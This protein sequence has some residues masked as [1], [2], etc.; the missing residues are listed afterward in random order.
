MFIEQFGWARGLMGSGARVNRRRGDF[1]SPVEVLEP[2]LLF[3][4][5]SVVTFNEIMYNPAASDSGGE[6][7]ELHNQ[8]SV[9]VDLS[10]WRLSDG[11][12]YTFAEGTTLGGGDYLVVAKDP[13]ALELAAGINNVFG[14]WS[15]SLSNSGETI[16]LRDH[17]NR[18]MDELDYN[19]AG[20]FPVA[21]D[22]SGASLAKT[23][24]HAA[25]G[26]PASW[27]FS[28]DSGGTPGSVN[29]VAS[30]ALRLSEVAGAQDGAFIVEIENTGGSSLNLAGYA[31]VLA[32][33]SDVTYAL[34]GSLGAGA[35]G[36]YS[37][38]ATG[39][40][41]QD[42]D[43]L[44]LLGPGGAVIDGTRVENSAR[45]R[46][47][48]WGGRWQRPDVATFGG[49]NSFDFEEAIVINEI[50]YH[51]LPIDPVAP[52]VT[53]QQL[54][55][56]SSVWRYNQSGADQGPGWATSAHSSGVGGWQ[57]GAGVLGLEGATLAA[58][59]NTT[60]TLGPRTFYFETDF[61]FTGDPSSVTQLQLT[62]LVDDGA[63]FYLNGV[64]VGTRINLPGGT[65]NA[66]T[67]ANP[68]VDNAGLGLMT[69]DA[70]Q[71]VAGTNR[72][73]VEVHQASTTSSDI[74]MGVELE[75]VTVTDPGVPFSED[76]EEWIELY[77][78]GGV[79]V[80]LSGWQ[81]D[82]GIDFEFLPGTVLGA[83][84][85]LVIARNATALGLKYPSIT[86]AGQYDGQL[87]NS[88]ERI[89]LVDNTGNLADEV[90]YYDGGAWD[91]RAD[92]GG[93]SLELRDADADN[94]NGQAWAASEAADDSQWQTVSY[95]A[96]ATTPG[97]G[98]NIWNEFVFG[99]LDD[100][101]IL[102][103]DISVIRDPGG[104][105]Q[106]LIQ[107]GSFNNLSTWRAGGNHRDVEI[108]N[109]NGN[110]VLHLT[111]TGSAEHILNHVE[112]TLV[113]NTAIVSGETYQISYRAKW[114]SGSNQLNT[115]LYF[116]YLPHTERLAR[117]TTTGTPG[118]VNSAAE[119]NIGPTYANLSQSV[120]TPGSF[121]SVT[122]SVDAQ[123]PDGVA[124][125]RLWYR[126]NEGSWQS[127][128]MAHNGGGHYTGTIPGYSSGSIIQFYVEGTDG[129]GAQ[130]TFPADGRDS[131]ALYKVNTSASNSINSLQII[132]L[133]SESSFLHVNTNT[134]SNDRVGAT[135][136]DE[137]G[138]IYYD[139]N[140]R[141]KGSAFGRNNNSTKGF[142]VGFNP[143]DRYRGVHDSVT[144]NRDGRK[145]I[146]AKHLLQAA[147]GVP[148]FYDDVIN[149]VS[150]SGSFN[151]SAILNLA[152]YGDVYL[153]GQ[154]DNGSDG[155]VFNLELLYTPLQTTNGN[156]ESLKT[157]FPY[158]HANGLPDFTS[159]GIDPELYR[160]NFQLEN[161]NAQDDF[162]GLINFV[163][164]FD[165]S[166]DA[167]YQAA[168][169]V[170]DIDQFARTFTAN[171]LVG[172]DDTYTRTPS[173][174][175][176]HNLRLFENPEDGRFLAMPWD[177][178]RSFNLSTGDSLWGNNGTLPNLFNLP[179]VSRLL[180]GHAD[181]MIQ[182]TFNSSYVGGWASHYGSLTGDN[183]SGLTSYV[184]N[185]ANSILGQ[186]PSLAPFNI[187][188]NGG[189]GFTINTNQVILE[190]TGSYKIREL[191]AD[192]LSEPFNVTWLDDTTWQVTLNL[193]PGVNSLTLR[194][195][196]YFGNEIHSDAITVTSTDDSALA[197]DFLR[198]TEINYH[199]A[200]PIAAEL[201]IDPNLDDNDFEF[202]E[203]LN[204]ST[205]QSINLAGVHFI[206]QVIN[207]DN[208][209]ITY[210]FG[211]TVLAPGERIVLVD[212]PS[213]FA[214]RYPGVSIAGNYSGNLD[215]GGETITLR[216]ATGQTIQQFTYDDDAATNWPTTPDGDG[217]SLVVINIAGDYDDGNNWA[218]ST[219]TNGTP[220]TDEAATLVGDLNNDG[221]VGSTDL[222]QLLAYWGRPATFSAPA[223]VADLNNDGSVN[224]PDL[225]L[226]IANWG[227]G[228]LPSQPTSNPDREDNGQPETNT[229]PATQPEVETE[230]EAVVELAVEPEPE[231]VETPVEPEVPAEPVA[232]PKPKDTAPAL[233]SA[234]EP[235]P[236]T[237]S[238]PAQE[239]M[240]LAAQRA[241]A[242]SRQITNALTLTRPSKSGG[243]STDT[244][245]APRGKDNPP[246]RFD[247]L[248]LRG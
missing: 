245:N 48:Q 46:S 127:V 37:Q 67:L 150:A 132:M 170:L 221:Y 36:V 155:N 21:A 207:D 88:G 121:Q 208:Q 183:F 227:A 106:Q 35:F 214:I 96:V 199:P 40:D 118:A 128:L 210:T 114:L 243:P 82:D 69:L 213:A 151:G 8:L 119:T 94:N 187:T 133:D 5:D 92:G 102:I 216:D 17:N 161:N 59:I 47:E 192:G 49:T 27:G 44:F 7:V 79:A 70:S 158:N 131:R 235:S 163:S 179:Q 152:R 146:L 42:E 90:T 9:D 134:F 14:G 233:T 81:F 198:I 91:G 197:R 248:A 241:T 116:N 194:A 224:S 113:G 191:Y 246:R 129:N 142:W 138:K 172:T 238:R 51:Q 72:L 124:S 237:P 196:D 104:A 240:S 15:G 171:S 58:P 66:S 75:A 220:G 120:V 188:T 141:L 195:H 32:G 122:I 43:R 110:N 229:D 189:N 123:D 28:A 6:W 160:Y 168:G 83:G 135:V 167:L 190:G 186:L 4:G 62:H 65:V 11:V 34:S 73:S 89:Q 211:D 175:H 71:L 206:E 140:T 45:A 164:T 130:S 23:S 182:T 111:T 39:M 38:A 115:R 95:T 101:E 236:R 117:P 234:P 103:D 33:S 80:D 193:N 18:V 53:T 212:D 230:S 20:Q 64:E 77:N 226:L 97:L 218:A 239:P 165:L 52:T 217:P 78:N 25:T 156:P 247:A 153:D 13:S 109:D 231:V 93:S 222:S 162:F 159:Y 228:T 166:G 68:G 177:L 76:P 98:N 139:V 3:S 169:Q 12:D 54:I 2:R 24:E 136:I 137:T 31:L 178:D 244:A 180:Y 16:R 56:F 41:P 30:S 84:E 185:R 29:S 149:F 205:T 201:L 225:S 22:G 173:V 99:L 209:G 174:H 57:L 145:E 176:A 74:V 10:G 143:E 112:T 19:D 61:T 223:D 50:L 86:I 154:Y 107:N 55:N 85:Y 200:D 147:G 219:T 60:L 184:Q 144:L 148:G 1:A 215:N 26:D 108:I 126:R 203:L 100:G 105:D 181:H 125:I 63:V 87:S 202:I 157:S 232:R 204:T 242:A